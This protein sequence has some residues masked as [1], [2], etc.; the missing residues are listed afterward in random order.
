MTA[1]FH[2]QQGR[3]CHSLFQKW[4]RLHPRGFFLTFSAKRRA[5][6]HATLCR[7][8][9]DVDWTFEDVGQ[10]L[11]SKRKVCQES[12][13]L[14][15]A[16]ADNR[17]G[18]VPLRRLPSRSAGLRTTR[19]AFQDSGSSHGW[20]WRFDQGRPTGPPRP[21]RAS[22]PCCRFNGAEHQ[23]SRPRP[24]GAAQD[25]GAVGRLYMGIL[26]LGNAVPQFLEVAAALEAARG[27]EEPVFADVRLRRNVRAPGF[28]GTAFQSVVGFH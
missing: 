11:T 1:E 4:R 21:A 7:H 15:L 20:Q 28:N 6:L 17:R 26:G 2:D 3:A 22:R 23:E 18:G 12:E 27:F 14:L 5:R 8:S 19:S 13:E 9:G 16:W 24:G 25:F 10:S